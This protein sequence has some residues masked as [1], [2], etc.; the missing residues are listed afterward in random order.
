M[1]K[2]NL[3]KLLNAIGKR[4]F[5]Q[6]FR[7]FRECCHNETNQVMIA[8]LQKKEPF[9]RKSCSSRTAKARRIF[10]KRLEEEALSIIARSG[11]VGQKVTDK[12]NALLIELRGQPMGS[13]VKELIGIMDGLPDDKAREVVNFARFL[14]QQSSGS[15]FA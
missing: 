10:Q 15:G 8:L 5:V 2:T 3:N 1:D 12:A 9:T 6:Y 11:R 14:K 13:A 4:V 7:E